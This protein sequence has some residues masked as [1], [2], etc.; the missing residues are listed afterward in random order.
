ML[1]RLCAR[2]LN[3]VHNESD[4]SQIKGSLYQQ[5]LKVFKTIQNMDEIVADCF[6][7]WRRSR[8]ILILLQ[9]V[10]NNVITGEELSGFS[11]ETKNRLASIRETFG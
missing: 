11:E 7:D 10:R 5:Y 9:L 2:I 8:F 3:E 6:D 4:G 1:E